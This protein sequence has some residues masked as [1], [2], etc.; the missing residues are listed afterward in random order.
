LR[1]L[2]SRKKKK[3]EMRGSGL[4]EKKKTGTF[5]FPGPGSCKHLPICVKGGRTIRSKKRKGGGGGRS[6]FTFGG[7]GI[8][9]SWLETGGKSVDNG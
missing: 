3:N 8:R 9:F 4:G 5:D 6:I 7:E 1:K 2:A